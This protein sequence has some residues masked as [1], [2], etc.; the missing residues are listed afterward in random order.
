MEVVHG[1]ALEV[2]LE[3]MFSSNYAKTKS[4][5]KN[6]ITIALSKPQKKNF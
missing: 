6:N 5:N 3:L 4:F 1:S 2:A